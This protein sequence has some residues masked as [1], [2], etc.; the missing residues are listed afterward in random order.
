VKL[1][2]VN[3]RHFQI[4][5]ENNTSS[6]QL[7]LMETLEKNVNED[8]LYPSRSRDK[9]CEFISDKI[10]AREK[11]KKLGAD[12]VGERNRRSFRVPELKGIW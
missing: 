12:V 6:W 9:V 10:R 7:I 11:K 5:A 4:V 2:L 8:F 3:S 1:T